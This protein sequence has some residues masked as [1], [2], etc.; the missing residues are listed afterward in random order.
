[1]SRQV[2]PYVLD[3]G[4]SMA[5]LMLDHLSAVLDDVTLARLTEVQLSPTGR[6]WE[7]AAGNGSIARW[8]CRTL[9]PTAEV[10]ASDINARH[11][12]AT[13]GLHVLRRNDATDGPLAG[14]WDGIHARLALAHWPNRHEVL[15]SYAQALRP[16]G[17]LLVEDWGPWTGMVLSSPVHGA[18]GIYGR[19]QD[20]LGRVFRSRGND[21]S[22]A[23]TTAGAMRAIGLVEVTT[24]VTAR[25]WPG[26]SPGCLLPLVVATELRE[27][28]IAHNADAGELDALP[29]IM[30]APGTIV[31]G[32]AIWSTIGY[33]PTTL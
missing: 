19:Y 33:T 29:S 23:T 17:W 25:S 11:I 13:A 7:V 26:G 8:L 2:E 20:A 5:S 3:N 16:G 6:F 15:A 31:L 22:W 14:A 32:N 30:N 9:G 21:T 10:V 28:L 1:M 18:A 4:E 27:L 12:P 24:T